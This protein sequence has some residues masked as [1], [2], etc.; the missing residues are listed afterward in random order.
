MYI[1]RVSSH[2][3]PSLV[4]PVRRGVP[5]VG[6]GDAPPRAQ[7]LT[8]EDPDTAPRSPVVQPPID[9]EMRRPVRERKVPRRYREEGTGETPLSSPE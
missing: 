5:A 2:E 4:V 1:F 7:S 3:E 9:I 6:A 8:E